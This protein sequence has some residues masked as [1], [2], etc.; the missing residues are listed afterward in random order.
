[1]E[2][3]MQSFSWRV[4]LAGAALLAGSAAFPSVSQADTFTLTSCHI[5]ADSTQP[6]AGCGTATSFGTVTLTQATASTVTVDVVLTNG[7]RFVETGAG[8]D[9]LFLFNDT[10]SGSTVTNISATL[11]TTTVTIPG[12]S[13]EPP[14]LRSMPTGPGISPPGSFARIHLNAMGDPLRISMISI[15]PLPA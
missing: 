1:M 15:L 12:A 6:T 5:T 13:R 3:I 11:N 8:A 7:N 10:V 14:T 4:A 9:S 2:I